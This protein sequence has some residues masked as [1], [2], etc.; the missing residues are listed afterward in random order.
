[1]LLSCC[2]PGVGAGGILTPSGAG[3]QE[4]ALVAEHPQ[5]P[6][7]AFQTLI[8]CSISLC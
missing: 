8:T 3:N 6:A 4:D 2:G 7:A 5:L 1:M